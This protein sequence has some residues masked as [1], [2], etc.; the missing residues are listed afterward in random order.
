MNPQSKEPQGE[1]TPTPYDYRV[2]VIVIGDAAVGK[3][4]IAVRFTKGFFSPSYIATLGVNFFVQ[5]VTVDDKVLRCQL[6][7]TAG[8]ERFGPVLEK[9]YVGAKG[10]VV[11]FDKTIPQTLA[12]VR[13]W[14]ER[15]KS[16]CGIIPI[17]L[18]G[19]KADLKEAVTSAQGENFAEIHQI[20]YLETS[21]K[22][23]MNV[24]RVFTLL[25][26]DIIKSLEKS[27]QFEF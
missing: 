1:A 14:L 25:A 10:A 18:V 19:N 8:Q 24:V 7:D 5:N 3:T 20:P 23:G 22:T 16:I 15:V 6:W 26:A 11:V 9:Y 12:N 17:I 21:A 13:G 27:E 2:K 4:S